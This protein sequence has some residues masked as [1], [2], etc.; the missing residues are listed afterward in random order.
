M[1]IRNILVI[2]F[3]RVGDSVLSMG[4]CHTLRESFPGAEIDFVIN[5]GIDSLYREHPDIDNVIVYDKKECDNIFKYIRKTRQTMKVKRYDIIIDMRSTVKSSL[6]SLFSLG[7]KYRIGRKKWY[8]RLL[9]THTV[10][11]RLPGSRPEQNLLLLKPLE[12]KYKIKYSTDFRLYVSKENVSEMRTRMEKSGID[13]S[14]PV[15]IAA[16]ATRV[17]GKAW[18]FDRM[19]AVLKK[20]IAKYPQVQIVFNYSKDEK[21]IAL[22]YY[23]A[24]DKD[25]H[26]FIN[27]HA[28]SLIE[29][30][31]MLSNSSMF[32][33]NEGGPRH[34]AQALGIPAYAIFPPGIKKET[35]LHNENEYN[36]GISPDDYVSP[37][38]QEKFE[39]GYKER[40][41]IMSTDRVWNGMDR[42][43][44]KIIGLF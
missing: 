9:L 26:I 19:T 32:F 43:M 12:N 17:Q 34:M 1:E 16:V 11:N 28:D 36:T 21:E 37:Q 31:A 3:R 39:M 15:L 23:N 18:P 24:L 40:M 29:L 7:T 42:F 8:S 14:R 10:N 20:A 22:S 6:F 4:L 38:D 25:K 30:C 13:F 44:D 2:R 27:I 5:K 33:G 35:W 41:E